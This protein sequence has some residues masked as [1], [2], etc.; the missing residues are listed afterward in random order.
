MIFLR[1]RENLKK[2]KYFLKKPLQFILEYGIMMVVIAAKPLKLRF[3]QAVY[4]AYAVFELVLKF[5]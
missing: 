5:T 2:F 1:V 3:L 4:A